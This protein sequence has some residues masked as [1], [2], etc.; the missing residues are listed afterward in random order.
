MEV[1]GQRM[2]ELADRLVGMESAYTVERAARQQSEQQ[3]I[4][5]TRQMQTMTVSTASVAGPGSLIDT[6]VWGKPRKL[7]GPSKDAW[8]DW[9]PVMISYID[10][11]G[12]SPMLAVEAPAAAPEQPST[13]P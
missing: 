9:E 2:Q 4:G 11:L 5:L 6:R 7:D 8:R 12:R 1:M 3:V 13:S 10:P